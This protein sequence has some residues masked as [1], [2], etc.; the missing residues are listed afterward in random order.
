MHHLGSAA[1]NWQQPC[2]YLR[3][4]SASRGEGTKGENE[5]VKAM[6][7]LDKTW[8]IVVEVVTN[9]AGRGFWTGVMLED[10]ENLINV[11]K[12]AAVQVS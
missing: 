7:G 3:P 8:R 5:V 10:Y 2:Y 1:N 12:K 6:S 11:E 9:D 4:C